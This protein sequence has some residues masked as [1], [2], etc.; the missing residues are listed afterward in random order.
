MKKLM[1]AAVAAAAGGLM[2]IESANVVGYQEIPSTCSGIWERGATFNTIAIGLDGYS[3]QSIVPQKPAGAE[4][5]LEDDAANIAVTDEYG[6]TVEQYTYFIAGSPAATNGQAGWYKWDDDASA[7]VLATRTFVRGEAFLYTAPYFY[8]EATGDD[9]MPSTFLTSGEVKTEA[10]T[11]T[12]ACSGIWQRYNYRPTPISIQQLIPVPNADAEN[13]LQDDAANIAVIDEYGE[14]IE[15]YTYFIDGSPAATNGQAG[16]YI[17]DDGAGAYVRA[18]RVFQPGE[19]F[20]YTAPYYY[21]EATG[22]DDMPSDLNF[23]DAE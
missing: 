16:W 19:G 8:N 9:D 6:E 5:A 7:Y 18:T 10:K 2:A 4:N 20:I 1:F 23:A 12:S 13:E 11:V 21:N 14:T 3:I 22:E 17:W 15:Q